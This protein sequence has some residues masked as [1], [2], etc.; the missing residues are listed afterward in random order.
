[1]KEKVTKAS[2]GTIILALVVILI[3]LIGTN[4]Y[5]KVDE[6][7]QAV[8]TM[9]GKVIDVKTAG[10]YFKIPLIQ[11]VTKVDTTTKGM[12]I[13]YTQSNDPYDQHA[14]V[15]E[16]EALMITSDFNFVDIDFYL[17]YR[18]SD[19]EKFLFRSS[20]PIIILRNMT[21]SS[22]RSTVSDYTVDEVITTGKNQI[23]AE[24]REKLVSALIDADIG[25]EVVNLSIQ[26]AEPPTNVV[27]QAFKAVETAKQGADTAV[28][29]AKQYQNE[30]IPA[31]E[32][33]ADK[34]TQQAEAQKEARIAEAEGQT[35]RFSAMYDQYKLNPEVTRQRLFYETMEEILPGL[36]VIIDDGQ[37]QT[38][39]PLE[40]FASVEVK[41]G[42]DN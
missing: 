2:K 15:V 16:Y 27:M 21:Q 33:N 4:A 25:I 39:L 28:N 41:N 9:F 42:G 5:Y 34:I 18:V 1:M 7:E 8:V 23:Q 17:E 30:Q 35:A 32:A 14:D 24:V 3:V 6:Q 38:V 22:I 36:K 12:Q 40:E 20:E 13:G 26:D 19:P 11:T 29:N 31:A 37:T 10:L